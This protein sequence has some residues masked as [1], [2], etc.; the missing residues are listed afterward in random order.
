M[1]P[2]C[3]RYFLPNGCRV[4]RYHATAMRDRPWVTRFADGDPVRDAQGRPL[5]FATEA[6]ALAALRG[7]EAAAA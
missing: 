5:R 6:E 7:V 1:K 3:T 2:V 4:V